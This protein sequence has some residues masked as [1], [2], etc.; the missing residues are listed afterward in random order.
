MNVSHFRLSPGQCRKLV[1]KPSAGLFR[2]DASM[3]VDFT[4]SLCFHGL[5]NPDIRSS[6]LPRILP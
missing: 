2:T 4:H 3:P 6:I 5:S 1:D